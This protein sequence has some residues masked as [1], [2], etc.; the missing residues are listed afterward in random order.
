MTGQ[1]HLAVQILS[2]QTAGLH[3]IQQERSLVHLL[4]PDDLLGD[5]LRGGA[6]PANRQEDVVTQEV[7]EE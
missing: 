7:P 3:E 1:S 2:S 6:H 5:V 4:H